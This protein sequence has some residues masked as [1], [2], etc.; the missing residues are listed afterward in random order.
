MAI[1]L[2]RNTYHVNVVVRKMPQVD[3]IL[4]SSGLGVVKKSRS[5]LASEK[6]L[7]QLQSL[8]SEYDQPLLLVQANEDKGTSLFHQKS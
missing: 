7:E 4:S 5:E 8:V 2:L 3:Y 1:S 6:T